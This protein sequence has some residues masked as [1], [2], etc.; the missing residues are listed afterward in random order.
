MRK[1]K[2]TESQFAAALKQADASSSPPLGSHCRDQTGTPTILWRF[3]AVPVPAQ[4]A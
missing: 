4:A 2:F 3:V 1:S